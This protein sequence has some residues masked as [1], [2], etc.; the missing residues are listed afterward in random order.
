VLTSREEGE[1]Y[2]TAAVTTRSYRQFCGVAR[3]LDLV[4][5]RW[6][7]LVVRELVLGP[8]RFTDLQAGLP[9]IG[10]NVLSERLR[11][12]ERSGLVERRVLPPPAG[13]TVYGLTEYGRELEPILLSFGRWGAQSLGQ[14][15]P[16]Q[17]LRSGWI[18]VALRAFA[19]PEAAGDARGAVEFRLGDGVFHAQVGGGRVTVADGSA[20]EPD[21]VVEAGN[22]EL[23]AVLVGAVG[24]EDA[25][26]S[27]MIRAEGDSI[28][29]GVL[30]DVFRFRTSETAV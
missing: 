1:R 12:L 13:S 24:L 21:L 14:R 11:E 15:A 4:G 29:L 10:S 2:Y 30:T 26:A 6:A 22:D 5:E 8:K 28:L 23:L 19:R 20:A 16:D 9:G 17:T 3:A 25:L 27:G 18:G 7:L